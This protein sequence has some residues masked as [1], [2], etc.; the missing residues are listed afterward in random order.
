[1]TTSQLTPFLFGFGWPTTP[2]FN[3]ATQTGTKKIDVYKLS[4]C[5]D[6]LSVEDMF[7]QLEAND[8]RAA[9]ATEAG[10]KWVANTFFPSKPRSLATLRMSKGFTQRTLAERLEVTQPMIAKWERGDGLNMQLKTVLGLATA[11]GVDINEL[12]SILISVDGD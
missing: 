2:I 11:L 3:E 5:Q 6:E 12:I 10:T 8:L 4:G 1:M 9:A 7:V